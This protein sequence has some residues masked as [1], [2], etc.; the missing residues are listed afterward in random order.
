M[1]GCAGRVEM[2]EG[3]SLIPLAG[4]KDEKRFHIK[5]TTGFRVPGDLRNSNKQ[6]RLQVK[7][8]TLLYYNKE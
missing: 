3:R 1:E 2:I 5:E 6:E 4:W 7:R 8:W